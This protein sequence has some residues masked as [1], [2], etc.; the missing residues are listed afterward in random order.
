MKTTAPILVLAMA[1]AVA[2]PAQTTPQKKKSVPPA[3]PQASASQ[4]KTPQIRAAVIAR[5]SAYFRSS[6]FSAGSAGA[7]VQSVNVKVE[8]TQP[9]SGWAGK[10]RSSGTATLVIIGGGNPGTKQERRFDAVTEVGSDGSV[11]VVDVST[12]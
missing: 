4:D 8:S 9:M 11:R 12:N 5:V 1:L 10:Y 6:A 3:K 7:R 2:L